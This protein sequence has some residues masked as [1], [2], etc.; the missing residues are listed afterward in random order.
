VIIGTRPRPSIGTRIGS[1]IGDGRTA[2]SVFAGTQPGAH[3][4]LAANGVTVALGTVIR[5]GYGAGKS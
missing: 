2:A 1:R 3:F 4:A 5:L